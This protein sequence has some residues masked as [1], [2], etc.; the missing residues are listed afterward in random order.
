M[1][2]WMK[3]VEHYKIYFLF[4]MYKTWVKKLQRL[5]ILIL[6]NIIFSVIKILF[7]FFND[8]DIDNMFISIEI[9]YSKKNFKYFT[10]YLGNFEIKP[11]SIILPKT[12]VYSKRLWWWNSMDVFFWLKMMTYWKNIMIFWIKSATV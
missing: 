6:K 5:V 11:F 3:N 12:N 7:F 8:V 1:Q 2:I 10:G 9:S 4:I